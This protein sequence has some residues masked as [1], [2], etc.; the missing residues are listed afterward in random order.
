MGQIKVG[1][2]PYKFV[3][4]GIYSK[5]R[6]PLY[7]G[8]KLIFLGLAI[9]LRSIIGLLVVLIVLVLWHYWREKQEEKFLIKRYGKR[10]LDYKKKTFF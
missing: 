7:L 9:S 3:K 2:I 1:I 8:V 4:S 10:Y 5:I 6:H